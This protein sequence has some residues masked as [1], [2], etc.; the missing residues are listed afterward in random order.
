[1]NKNPRTNAKKKK[2]TNNKS[3]KTVKAARVKN[4]DGNKNLTTYQKCLLFPER[5]FCAR[6]PGLADTTIALK[7]KVTLTLTAN[8]LG[9]ACVIWQPNYLVDNS[10]TSSTCFTN[11][12]SNTTYDGVSTM[13]TAFPS[14]VTTNWNITPNAVAQFRLVSSAMHIVPQSS[15]LNQ[16][17]TIH[18]TMQKLQQQPLTASGSAMTSLQNAQLMALYPNF[19][20]TTYYN[21]ASV[22]AMEGARVVWVPNDECLL[23]FV[24]TNTNLYSLDGGY[25]NINTL[26]GVVVGA[27]AGATFRVDL[28]CNFEVTPTTGSILTGLE[29]VCPHNEVASVAWRKVLVDYKDMIAIADREISNIALMRAS[30]IT[31]RKNQLESVKDS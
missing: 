29:S 20:N 30:Q 16:A 4:N 25:Q 18:F 28:Y 21:A 12:A 9:A 11:L 13:G 15:V 23:E 8:L 3:V 10:L 5:A 1:M 6:V 17:G 24:N 2:K 22:S 31:N 19:Q 26:I 14:A 27:P 7:R